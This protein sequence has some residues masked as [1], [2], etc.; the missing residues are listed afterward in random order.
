MPCT[1]PSGAACTIVITGKRPDNQI[2]YEGGWQNNR[3]IG[4]ARQYRFVENIFEEL[5][6]PGEWFLDA[7][8]STLYFYPPAGVDLA[9]ATIEAVRLRHLVEFRGT[10]A[11]AGAVRHA[12]RA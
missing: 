5:D 11:G 1:P 10:R 9:T 3:P 8:T 6:A 7:K 4:H 12:S 2:T